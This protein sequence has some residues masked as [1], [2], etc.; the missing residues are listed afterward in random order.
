MKPGQVVGDPV[1]TYVALR[2]NPQND[3]NQF[4][5]LLC[6]LRWTSGKLQI[7][8]RLKEV[9]LQLRCAVDLN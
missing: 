9:P 7:L 2:K 4:Y 5:R 1:L 3:I 6:N 8:Y